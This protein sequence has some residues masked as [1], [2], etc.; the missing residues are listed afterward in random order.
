[1]I[2]S[3]FSRVLTEV[4]LIDI[5]MGYQEKSFEALMAVGNPDSVPNLLLHVEEAKML[6]DMKFPAR[7]TS[8]LLGRKL[9]KGALRAYLREEDTKQ[10]L[11]VPGVFHQPLV[12]YMGSFPCGISITHANGV[13]AA[14]VFPHQTPLAVDLEKVADRGQSTLEFMSSE[15]ERARVYAMVK[16]KAEAFVAI[17]TA[18]EALSKLLSCGLKASFEIFEIQAAHQIEDRLTFEFTHF[19]HVRAECWF[20]SGYCLSLIFP[21]ELSRL[22][23]KVRF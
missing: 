22:E 12:Q 1:M 2:S 3:L 23:L 17:W 11:V 21:K 8:F 5:R 6:E 9:A 18:K 20:F 13:G 7:Q 16:T 15:A 10:I 4:I 19:P 14:V